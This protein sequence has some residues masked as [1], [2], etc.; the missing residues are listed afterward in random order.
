MAH[1]MATEEAL[2]VLCAEPNVQPPLHKQNKQCAR[3]GARTCG[4][5]WIVCRRL[6]DQRCALSAA[7]PRAAERGA[8]RA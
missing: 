5:A 7:E 2:G 6:R 3:D 1:T 8:W 4:G